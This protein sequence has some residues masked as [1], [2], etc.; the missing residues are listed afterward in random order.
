[1]KAPTNEELKTQ[2]QHESAPPIQ[3]QPTHEALRQLQTICNVNASK[4]SFQ[5]LP[6]GL[7]GISME[8][9]IYFLNCGVNFHRPPYPGNAPPYQPGQ[10]ADQRQEVKD[11]WELDTVAY[12]TVN[13]TEKLLLN[14]VAQA[15]E[16]THLT[17]IYNR[18]LG[19]SGATLHQAFN[20]LFSTYGKITPQQKNDNIEAQLTDVKP[21]TKPTAVTLPNGILLHSNYEA[22][23]PITKL[24]A[25]A[26]KCHFLPGLQHALLSIG[27]PCDAGCLVTFTDQQCNMQHNGKIILQGPRDP[28]TK[29]WK[30]SMQPATNHALSAY[31]QQMQKELVECPHAA[32]FSPVKQTWIRAVNNN[33]FNTWPGLTAQAINKHLR[34]TM[35]TAKGHLDRQRKNV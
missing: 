1:M 15:I 29:L 21:A 28:L 33:Q 20:F 31:T 19:F 34:P 14:I 8:P 12:E 2:F 5:N 13:R 17:G 35:A 24:P 27:K 7:L 30:I 4:I 18:D 9:Q 3:G 11:Q 22:T 16:T 25:N 32:A 10:T 26:T 23:L 6:Q